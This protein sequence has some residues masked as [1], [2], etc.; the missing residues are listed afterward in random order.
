VGKIREREEVGSTNSGSAQR[1]V[2]LT[3]RDVKKTP[4]GAK[5]EKKRAG[6]ERSSDSSNPTINMKSMGEKW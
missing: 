2:K 4:E 3:V 5:S 1:R 6:S